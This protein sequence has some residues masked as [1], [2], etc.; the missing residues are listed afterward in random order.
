MAKAI[1]D[2]NKMGGKKTWNLKGL[3][4]GNGWISP[5]D[6]YESYGKF[7]LEKGLI[8]KDSDS[9]K[10]L[11][12]LLAECLKV[13]DK[14]PGHVDYRECESILSDM[15]K[16]LKKGNGDDACLNMYDVRLRD[17]YPSC[18][19]N[20]PPDLKNVT[21]YLRRRE[22]INAL[23]VKPARNTGWSECSGGVGSAFTARNSQPSVEFLPEVIEQV[24]TLLFS[25]AE[26]MI[27][28]HIGTESLLGNLEWNGAK[29]FE[30]TP[31]NW[32]PR[33]DWTFE[34]EAA[35]IWQEARNLTYV[36]FYNASHMVPF[37]Y[38]RRSRDMLDRFMGVDISSIGG[39]ASESRIDGE[40]GLETTVGGTSNKTDTD[41]NTQQQVDDAKWEAYRR[42]GEVV[43]IIVVIAA[44]GWGY[45]IWRE[46]RK[47]AR[48]Q[49]L[50][51]HDSMSQVA[52][53]GRRRK[54]QGNGDLEAAA[55]DERELD[56]L[57]LES[58]TTDKYS[59]GDDSD[60]EAKSDEKHAGP[61]NS[62]SR[63]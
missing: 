22:V 51:G 5:K 61:S 50:N 49:A 54:P 37:D 35:G 59:V 47:Q 56:D 46:R 33:R 44:A 14:D 6:H 15:L 29:G 48:Y 27:C 24:P 2:R 55:F 40:K 31:G 17:S 25:G 23:H 41:E 16:L 53:G 38:P 7:A 28:N 12:G 34:G 60:D 45:F 18:G 32:A 36:L 52:L 21:P 30:V 8:E 62:G 3:L 11:D 20:W 42:S 43:L 9:H 63:R 13:M 26:D 1:L 39:P 10:T 58:P 19:M 57:H 4:I